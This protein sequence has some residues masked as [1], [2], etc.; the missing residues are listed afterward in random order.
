MINSGAGTHYQGTDPDL[1]HELTRLLERVG[2]DLG[3]HRAGSQ[4][5]LSELGLPP[6]PTDG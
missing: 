3:N 6:T 1:L 2:G 5:L 4:Q